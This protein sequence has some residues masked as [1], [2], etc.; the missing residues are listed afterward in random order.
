[1]SC[2]RCHDHKF[3]PILQKDYYA[4]KAFFDPILLKDDTTLATAAELEEYQARLETWLAATEDVRLE[5]DEIMHQG[6]KN[7]E[8]RAIVKFPKAIR[9]ML[10]KPPHERSARETQLADIAYRQVLHEYDR[11]KPSG[12][13]EGEEKVKKLKNELAKFEHLKPKPLPTARTVCDVPT[14]APPTI[15]P[16]R[17]PVRVQPGVL[18]VLDEK[19]RTLEVTPTPFSSGRRTALA[20]WLGCDDNP[21][22]PR[23][24][25]NRVWQHHFGRAIA[26]NPSD[27][28]KLGDLPS[29]PAL[30]DWLAA[31]F[32]ENGWRMKPMHRLIMQSA[33]YRQRA[34]VPATEAAR[35]ADPRNLLLWRYPQRRHP[36]EV[37][38]DRMLWVSGELD[39]KRG[40]PSVDGSTPRRSVYVKV[41]RNAPD[42]LLNCFDTPTGATSTAVRN[43]TTTSTQALLM[44]NQEWVLK[45]ATA[46]ANRTTKEAR[47][48]R[49]FVAAAY[50]RAFNRPPTE[51][52]IEA[53]LRFLR[54]ERPPPTEPDPPATARV[55]DGKLHV[56]NG[57]LSQQVRTED[58][59]DLPTGDFTVEAV[60]QL[61]SLYADARVRVIAAHWDGINDHPGWSLGVTSTM[62]KYVPCNLILQLVG[63]DPDGF[64]HYE[65]LASGL[66]LELDRPYY[67]AAR[68]DIDD[69]STNGVTFFVQDLSDTNAALRSA[70]VAHRS[71]SDFT[72]VHPLTI[73]GRGSS[74]HG[75]DGWIDQL[76]LSARTLK[77]EELWIHGLHNPSPMAVREDLVGEWTFASLEDG[78]D[79]RQHL[80]PWHTVSPPE[81]APPNMTARIDFCHALL[82]AN[83]FVYGR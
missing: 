20:R 34:D 42:R 17:E 33:T 8:H 14:G 60:V 21:L 72:D 71:V 51:S 13:K 23:V 40:G 83:E 5:L 32:V 81:K 24:C 63:H 27:F 68:V 11:A 49:A 80:Q 4:L 53:G 30:L 41:R 3:D 82:N 52:E 22:T 62:S 7:A 2:A 59:E 16:G 12:G 69:P 66:H 48:D 56:R 28:G 58:H 31:T 73:G 45:R 6:M 38:R 35:K 65:V 54:E 77:D 36:G 25:A 19:L 67:V 75:W 61:D 26:E 78:S 37:V 43:Q 44:M 64:Q 1:M 47:E 29:H 9:A 76:R 79:R 50:E 55:A 57:A 10:R 15:L 18:T 74:K 39:R 46:F 70:G